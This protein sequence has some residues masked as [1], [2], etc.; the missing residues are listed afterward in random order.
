MPICRTLEEAEQAGRDLVRRNGWSLTQRQ[1]ERLTV[2]L[3]S[4]ADVLIP[5]AADTPRDAA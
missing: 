1:R 2:L 5:E 3:S 4:Y